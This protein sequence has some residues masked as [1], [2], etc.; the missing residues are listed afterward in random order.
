M[1]NR[2]GQTQRR[3]RGENS[4]RENGG[5]K[6][7]IIIV[8]CVAALVGLGVLIYTIWPPTSSFSRESLDEYV[9]AEY[10][11]NVLNPGASVYLDFSNGMNSAYASPESQ[12]ILKNI[13]NKLIGENLAI[14]FNSLAEGKITPL[15]GLSQTQLYNKIMDAKSYVKAGA[16]IEITLKEIIEKNQPAVLI[17]DFEEYNSGAIQLAAYAK[18][19]FIDWLSKGYNITFYKWDYNE[20][21]KA[22][23]LYIAIFDG[24]GNAALLSMVQDAIA[25]SGSTGID[26]F[27]LGGKDFAYPIVSNY[28]SSKQGGSYHDN[29]GQDIVSCV[30]ED[31]SSESYICYAKPIAEANAAESPKKFAPL[32]NLYGPVVEYYPLQQ[33]WVDIIANADAM[34]DHPDMPFK[35][36]LGNIY[37]NFATQDGFDINEIEA[38]V[39]NVMAEVSNDTT[40]T[41]EPF[42]VLDVFT[43]NLESVNEKIDNIGGWNEITL[44][45]SPHFK[46]TF[47][48]KTLATDLLRVNIVI[49]KATPKREK[50]ESFFAWDGNNSLASSVLNTIESQKVNPQGRVLISYFIKQIVE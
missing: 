44:D 16:P 11:E 28:P 37:I 4:R 10:K 41:Q 21:S 9:A 32:N 42:E 19:Y 20:G 49:S 22:K 36:L 29:E 47:N 25:Q 34:K 2:R 7:P 3:S 31:G 14:K 17:T 27:V 8:A 23:H 5:S 38:R 18:D 45:F 50:I 12:Q 26:R 43:A 1:A 30:L 13:T 24:Q 46:G 15:E 39:F 35:H 6:T 33:R 48:E 40:R